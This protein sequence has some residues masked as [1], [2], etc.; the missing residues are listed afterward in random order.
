M[1][2][3][4][5][6]L[7]PV[8]VSL[9]VLF[10]CAVASAQPA[11]SDSR[12]DRLA[13]DATASALALTD[14]QKASVATIISE[15]DTA[16]AAAENDEAKAAI[17][18]DAQTKLAAVLTEDQQTQ[19]A[20]LFTPPRIR[21]NFRFQKWAE[22]LTWIAGEADLSLVMEEAPEGTFNYSD[23]REYEPDEAIDLLNGWLMIKGFTLV[24]RDQLLMCVSL[25]D[26][27]PDGTIPQ[28]PLEELPDRGRFEFVSVLIP[29]DARLS[30]TVMTEIEPLVSAWGQA[31]PLA[32]TKQ[33]LVTDAA[34]NVR[35][36][37]RVVELVPPPKETPKPPAPQPPPKPELKVYPLQHA[38]PEKAGEVIKELI[39]GSL[40]VDAEAGQV[41]VNAIP[42]EQAKVQAIIDQLE[43]N[44]GADKQAVLKSYSV[45]TD[46]P[47]QLV[48]SVRL[49]VPA[50]TLRYD[51]GT[52]RL[53]AFAIP[54]DQQRVTAALLE[55]ETQATADEDQLTVHTLH[56]VDPNVA[57]QLIA[58]VLPDVRV[59][60]DPRS[61]MLIA[62]GRQADLRAVANLLNELQPG[63]AAASGP[64][65]QTYPVQEELTEMASSVVT[66]LVPNAT[67]TSDPAN[68]RLLV[69]ALPLDHERIAATL[70]R[71]AENVD[72]QDMQLKSLDIDGL[73]FA[74]VSSLLERLVPKAQLIDDSATKRLLVIAQA[75]DQ[76]KVSQ[77]LEQ[78]R[79]D[80]ETSR[81]QLQFYTVPEDFNE[82]QFNSLMASFSVQ[83]SVTVDEPNNRLMITATARGHEKIAELLQQIIPET[84]AEKP[85]LKTYPL[86]EQVDAQTFTSMLTTQTKQATVQTDTANKRLLITATAAGHEAAARLLEQLT[87]GLPDNEKQLRTY[88][89]PEQITPET[90]TT[91]L[92]T[93]TP[94]AT[95]TMDTANQQVLVLATAKVQAS[96]AS[97]LEQLG[98]SPDRMKRELKSYPLRADVDLST[99]TSLLASLVPNAAVT[100]DTTAHRLLITATTKDHAA[101]EA[102]IAQISRDAR[103][104]LPEL[105][106]Y[107]LE[108]ADGDYSVGV[109]SAIVPSATIR[110]VKRIVCR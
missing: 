78:I 38:N 84:P 57:Q 105:E 54:E 97:A 80:T 62:V 81:L 58:S 107:P 2:T 36:I 99:V 44:Q 52:G 3:I 55:L 70:T 68:Q 98:G 46:N 74:H 89:L 96:V 5:R 23:R 8:G 101:A 66:S 82:S 24:R 95:V 102:A 79:S 45:R 56:S 73:A 67:V 43:A 25:K 31:K 17:T 32:A 93:L 48:E 75:E 90:V 47:D 21:F 1:K 27:I 34:D 18:A 20:E 72:G 71:L 9:A 11:E 69:V 59:T 87:T 91:T 13:E 19:L 104:E 53:V 94:D 76:T 35:T 42:T 10:V 86:P 30:E 40:V 88:P 103:G 51:T 49:A 65:L 12:Y 15:R 22:V 28:I 14:E 109:L 106:Y 108:R 33:I 41:S 83:A 50:A 6:C 60:V 37:Q 92:A 100:P 85:Q 64:V 29:L 16:L 63:D 110:Y 7:A 61:S 4:L 39:A 77:V 26:G